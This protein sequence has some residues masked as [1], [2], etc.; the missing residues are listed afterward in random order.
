MELDVKE[1]IKFLFPQDKYF[2][3]TE[4]IINKIQVFDTPSN[5]SNGVV[6]ISTNAPLVIAK[7]VGM[8]PLEVAE[9]MVKTMTKT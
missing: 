4:D 7:S 3:L 6:S 2:L 1:C 9:I 5:I 8:K